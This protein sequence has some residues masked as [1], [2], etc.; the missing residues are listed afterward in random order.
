M[1][2]PNATAAASLKGAAGIRLIDAG[3]SSATTSNILFNGY[4]VANLQAD[5]TTD[6]T[7]VPFSA[8]N[9][10]W[11]VS[12]ASGSTTVAPPVNP[13]TATTQPFNPVSDGVD[14]TGWRTG[15]KADPTTGQY[16]HIDAPLP[17]ADSAPTS[18]L[19]SNVAKVAPGDSITLTANAADDFGV[20][21]LTFYKGAT[22]LGTVAPPNDSI[23]WTAPATCGG[24]TQ[25]FS[26]TVV[27][28]DNQSSSSSVSV[29]VDDCAPTVDLAAAP[30]APLGTIKLSA[31]ASDDL[32]LAKLEFYVDGDLVHTVNNPANGVTSYDYTP[33]TLCGADQFGFEVVATDSTGHESNDSTTY[34]KDDCDPV[35][36][37]SANHSSVDPG[38]AVD[39]TA[40]AEDDVEV[41][42]L[43][44]YKAASQLAEYTNADHTATWTKVH[45][46][47]ASNVCGT[48]DH[49]RVVAEDNAGQTSE[50]T[51]DVTTTACPDN[52][53]TV[54]LA[55]NPTAVDPGGDVVL[56]ATA[57]DDDG[58]STIT[59]F[60]GSTQ[61]GQVTPPANSIH[62][63]APE[64]C[65]GTFTLKAVAKDTAD[66]TAEDTV[67]V[68]T[69]AC[70]PPAEP[71]VS[72]DSPPASIAQNGTTVSATAT[73]GVDVSK[74]TFFL[75][76]RQV[77]EDTA[78]PFSC[79]IVPNG[80]EVGAQSIRAVVTDSLAR[81]AE[82]VEST[83]VSKFK[84]KALNLN[85][86]RIGNKKLRIKAYGK[87]VLP[88]RMTA[89]DGCSA[90]R[91]GITAKLGKK[92]LVN[93]QI[94][95]ASDCTYGLA[96]GAPKTKKKQRVV[97][98]VRFAG[99]DSL[100]AISQVRKVR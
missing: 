61:I 20:K 4:G 71:T 39:L 88:A 44:F 67:T 6:N 41:A 65:N 94:K 56:T 32:G 3:A 63:T 17:V 19:S 42:K 24:S 58:V 25:S 79:N 38:G 59:F 2:G 62:W 27:D 9:N 55:A 80:D 13:V 68:T 96:F 5:G 86:K 33:A 90:S 87:L 15:P 74:V 50:D 37:L 46:T 47:T 34:S 21:S 30:T 49:F 98:T 26:V 14:T 23:E 81:T 22:V 11:G 95:L 10:Y 12:D 84:P 75:G 52:P 83:T 51:V 73:S 7:A 29:D 54:D 31:T 36:D 28:S 92:S 45:S 1:A 91:V 77:C 48:T 93:K 43:T 16:P 53:P 69:N 66:Q 99:N 82:D 57:A 35:V 18:A 76:T 72:I 89:A 100:S 60:E 64:T 97:I 70:P 40:D 78:A 8:L 85:S